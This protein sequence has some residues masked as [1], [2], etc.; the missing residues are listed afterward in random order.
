MKNLS[1]EEIH[2]INGGFLSMPILL[3]NI[4]RF[5]F[6]TVGAIVAAVEAA[7]EMH[8]NLTADQVNHWPDEI[9]KAE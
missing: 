9:G 1:K 5:A 8:S 6:R 3:D 7:N 2:E 4:T